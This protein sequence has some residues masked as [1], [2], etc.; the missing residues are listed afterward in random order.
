ML[1]SVARAVRDGIQ[2]VRRAAAFRRAVTELRRDPLAAIQEGCSILDDLI[3]GW[4]NERRSSNT[5]FL[6]ACIREAIDAR[7]PI[8]ECDSGLST[9]VLGVVAQRTGNKVWSLEHLPEWSAHVRG[10]LDRFGI[11]SAVLYEA[12][13][14]SHGEYEWY[15]PP[16]SALSQRYSL[17]VC[18]GPPADTR[19]GRYGLVP[20]MR[21]CLAKG[22]VILLDDAEREAEQRTAARWAE[23][24]ACQCTQQGVH[25]PFFR[26]VV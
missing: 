7:G 18:D 8:L 15:A 26:L 24:L 17:V 2:D 4:H 16:A 21:S 13:L 3:F 9:I 22:S 12:P 14:A 6:R 11:D 19:G 10:E 25:K 20:T 1:R 5:E 23:E